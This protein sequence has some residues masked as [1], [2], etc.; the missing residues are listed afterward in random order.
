MY[1][2]TR[3]DDLN[4]SLLCIKL[5]KYIKHPTLVNF[6]GEGRRLL[7]SNSNFK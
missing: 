3:P 6:Q 5:A 7:D 4:I 2:N 1:C